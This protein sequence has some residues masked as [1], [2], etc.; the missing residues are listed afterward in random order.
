MDP[1]GQ[2]YYYEPPG[3]PQPYGP[4][5]YTQPMPVAS[6]S[7]GKIAIIVIIG[8][9][10]FIMIM[11]LIFWI[12]RRTGTG[13][14]LLTG[15]FP[16]NN[17][18]TFNNNLIRQLP[19]MANTTITTP[20]TPINVS[21]TVPSIDTTSNHNYDSD[22]ESH[23]HHHHRRRRK[24][25]KHRDCSSSSSSSSSS[26]EEYTKPSR[27]HKHRSRRH[28]EKKESTF[29]SSSQS[30]SELEQSQSTRQPYPDSSS[31]S[32][33][34]V[35]HEYRRG[36]E[37]IPNTNSNTS[38]LSISNVSRST[39]SYSNSI[40]VKTRTS[41][42]KASFKGNKCVSMPE[43]KGTVD[44][45]KCHEG[46]LYV[47]VL[48]TKCSGIYKYKSGWE[49]LLGTSDNQN[50]YSNNSNLDSSSKSA[51]IHLFVTSDENIGFGTII[52]SYALIENGSNVSVKKESSPVCIDSHF[53]EE[54]KAHINTKGIAYMN[55]QKVGLGKATDL[56][57]HGKARVRCYKGS[58]I[59]M[60]DRNN[61]ISCRDKEL[62][63]ISK[64]V[65]A[66]DVCDNH[67][68]YTQRNKVSVTDP[69]SDTITIDLPFN[70]SHVAT[71]NSYIYT[72]T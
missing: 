36:Q 61:L 38:I 44:Y 68:A 71:S 12:F 58:L 57:L 51:I 49:C 32:P 70:A 60:T 69:L 54:S 34:S 48:G 30:S 6:D 40:K 33:N 1:Y 21:G 42:A 15:L 66:Y 27:R 16:V 19:L 22:S 10:L 17:P 18:D 14:G 8:M 25:K 23:H 64:N 2:G 39:N 31:R 41:F 45:M 26:E 46:A 3:P 53:N 24:E 55:D 50:G 56:R 7:G 13:N 59:V 72:C 63:T 65:S 4:G 52:Q 20:G 35:T 67:I 47:H 43:L 28:K 29:E 37:D 5:G 62:K 11:L 9:I